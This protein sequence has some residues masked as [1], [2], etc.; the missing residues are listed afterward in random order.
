MF[1]PRRG[2]SAITFRHQAPEEAL[3]T[4]AC[5]GFAEIDLGALPG[6]CDHVPYELDPAAVDAVAETVRSSGLRVRSINGDIGDLNQPLSEGARAARSRHLD[7]L[8]ALAAT[9][10]ARALV[11]PCGA[12]GHRSLESLDADLDR[13]ADKLIRAAQRA[14]R[15]GVD[16]DT[17]SMHFHRHCWKLGH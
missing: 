2:C 16:G 15:H 12:I 7:M 13:V 10:G 5:L 3:A 6:V 4:I 14:G 11:L 17:E 9:T 8:I 1:H